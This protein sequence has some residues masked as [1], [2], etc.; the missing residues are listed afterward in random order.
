MAIARIYDA[1][2]WSLDDYDRVMDALN[3]GGYAAT[4]VL[5]NWCAAT[6]TGLRIVDVYESSEIADAL[7]ETKIRP[8]VAEMGL[9]MP[10][11]VEH[12]VHSYLSARR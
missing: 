4:G 6:E 8:T 10:E 12:E 3:L 9:T 7:G 1:E 2:G 5:F 11:M